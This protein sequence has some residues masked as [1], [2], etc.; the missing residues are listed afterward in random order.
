MLLFQRLKNYPDPVEVVNKYGADAL[1][2]YLI[3]SPVVRAESL[4]F[5]EDGVFDLVKIVFLPW[6]HA[7]RCGIENI[8]RYNTQYNTVFQCSGTSTK[9]PDSDNLMDQWIIASLGTLIEFIHIE[10]KA[11]RLYTVVPRLLLFIEN[12]TN[13][14]VRTNKRRLKGVN[15]QDDCYTA[16]N[17][18]TYVLYQL[19]RC[20]APFTPFIVESMY[21]NIKTVLQSTEQHDSI[22]YIMLPDIQQST[23]HIIER[24]VK[25][26]QS[27]VELG[28]NA[29]DNRKISM[30]RPLRTITVIHKTQQ[31]LDDVQLLS[32]YVTDELNIENIVFSNDINKH[33]TLTA[34]PNR[35]LLGPRLGKSLNE[36]VQLI[37]ELTQSQLNEFDTNGSITLNGE[38]FDHNDIETKLQY[39][40]NA[41]HNEAVYNG[42]VLIILDCQIDDALQQ[43]YIARELSNRIQR[44][45]KS[46]KL[47]P[48]D[49][50]NIYSTSIIALIKQYVQCVNPVYVG[51]T[52]DVCIDGNHIHLQ[53]PIDYTLTHRTDAINR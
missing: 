2:L 47:N 12:L 31:Y 28:R 9:L 40:G 29:R 18:L 32:S 30:K 36:Y 24:Q 4:R 11:Y 37:T 6:Y 33:A 19:C 48:S 8:I 15:G 34:T 38:K 26:M 27:V 44:T 20:M 25:S 1:R 53:R 43:Q 39:N 52:I 13:W 17:I 35:K 10:M 21:Q 23:N 3:S 50:I 49:E 5:R 41:T 16:L 14:Y 42:D 45:R 7:Y 46:S 22:H 51:S